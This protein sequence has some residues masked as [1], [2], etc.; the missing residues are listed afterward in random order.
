MVNNL[1]AT[2]GL[3]K[4]ACT[5]DDI[6]AAFRTLARKYHPDKNRGENS[7]ASAEM[8]RRLNLA[9]ETLMDPQK[10]RW[11]DQQLNSNENASMY[12]ETRKSN[13]FGEF[14]SSA[15]LGA[16]WRRTQAPSYAAVPRVHL[17][18][19]G[20][21][22]ARRQCREDFKDFWQNVRS[23]ESFLQQANIKHRDDLRSILLEAA[24]MNIEPS[25]C[26]TAGSVRYASRAQR[27][28]E[29]QREKFWG[30]HNARVD[31]NQRVRD[32]LRASVRRRISTSRRTAS[33]PITDG[34]RFSLTPEE[35]ALHARIA[36]GAGARA[37]DAAK[38][39]ERE[40]L[41]CAKLRAQSRASRDEF[42]RRMKDAGI[43]LGRGHCG[44]A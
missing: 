19:K 22:A 44:T 11:H 9:Y 28:R 35:K 4:G 18:K 3:R 6:K 40:T 33:A 13:I 36:A 16:R 38:V 37:Y 26:R 7:E 31:C 24:E 34:S 17:S 20:R 2:L 10:R 27:E 15:G 32:V 30:A 12:P 39:A 42:F 43:G 8:M 14:S 41:R 1:Y 21:E 5:R 23:K 29:I 25:T